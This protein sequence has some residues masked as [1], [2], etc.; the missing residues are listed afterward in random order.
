MRTGLSATFVSES[1]A[2]RSGQALIPLMMLYHADLPAVICRAGNGT[3]VPSNGLTYTAA[4]IEV[5]LPDD[6]E[7]RPTRAQVSVSDLDGEIVRAVRSLAG[8]AVAPTVTLSLVLLDSPDTVQGSA[9]ILWLRDWSASA[10]IWTGELAATDTASEPYPRHLL[11]P[12]IA[13]G[14]F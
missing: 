10:G 13:P 12:E 2:Q 6:E 9:V 5:K 1:F 4:R 14:M 11:T 7:G 8:A 3:D